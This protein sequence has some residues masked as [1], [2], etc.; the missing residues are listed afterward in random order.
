VNSVEKVDLPERR[1]I[2]FQFI[3]FGWNIDS[4]SRATGCNR[5]CSAQQNEEGGLFQ[6]NFVESGRW[7]VLLFNAYT[8]PENTFLPV[9]PMPD[10]NDIKVFKVARRSID[11]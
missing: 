1:K 10:F 5:F 7:S 4:S 6:Q 2:S 11:R 3:G 9:L 8:S